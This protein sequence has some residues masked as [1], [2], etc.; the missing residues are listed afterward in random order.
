MIASGPVIDKDVE[1]ARLCQ[2]NVEGQSDSDGV[3][4]LV[5]LEKSLNCIAGVCNGQT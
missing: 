5:A 2:A 4:I 3:S 1:E